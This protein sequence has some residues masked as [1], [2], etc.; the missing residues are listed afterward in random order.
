MTDDLDALDDYLTAAEKAARKVEQDYRN[1]LSFLHDKTAPLR[2]IKGE[3]CLMCD[4]PRMHSVAY[5]RECFKRSLGDMA[6][7]G[8]MVPAEAVKE[9]LDEISSPKE[10]PVC[11]YRYFDVGHRLLYVGISNEPDK[12][13]AQHILSSGWFRF[14]AAWSIDW[15]RDRDTAARQELEAIQ[16]ELPLF[17]RAGTDP[18]RDARARAYLL[19]KQAFDLLSPA[20]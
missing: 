9:L 5:C 1:G 20:I 7:N 10:K 12:R 6:K 8:R 16:V 17:N 15:Y 18:E 19:A 13:R 2:L 4:R 14:V 3:M 11:V